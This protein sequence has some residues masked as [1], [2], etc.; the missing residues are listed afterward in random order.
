MDHLR[1]E[2]PT[3][4]W[5]RDQEHSPQAKDQTRLDGGARLGTFWAHCKSKKKCTKPRYD[6]LLTNPVLRADYRTHP[7][8]HERYRQHKA[9]NHALAE[10]AGVRLLGRTVRDGHMSSPMWCRSWDRNQ[11]TGLSGRWVWRGRSMP[12]ARPTGWPAASW[13]PQLCYSY[14]SFTSRILTT[15]G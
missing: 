2:L 10:M 4:R 12:G 15:R 11:L 6:W 5:M 8:R 7:A 13:Q 9:Q 3:L 14:M 1:T